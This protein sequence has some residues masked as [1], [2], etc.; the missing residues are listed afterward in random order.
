MSLR[1]ILQ[2]KVLF[3]VFLVVLLSA[4]NLLGQDNQKSAPPRFS[5]PPEQTQSDPLARD[6]L[7]AFIK[8][9]WEAAIREY[10]KLTKLSPQVPDYHLNL[11]ISYYS[12]GRPHE[13]VE[14]LRQALKLKPSLALARYYLGPSLAGS[15]QCK[16][17]LSYL[18]KDVSR[19]TEKH[20][21]YEMGLAGVRCSVALNQPNDTV[22][23]IRMLNREFPD[24][25]EVL[26]QTVH[27]YSDLSTRASQEIILRAPTSYQVHLLN[28]EVLESQGKWEDAAREYRAVLE[29]NPRLPGIHFRLGRLFLSV[30][31]SPTTVENARKEFEEE[32]KID[33]YNAGAEYVLGELDL[34][35]PDLDKA[36]GHLSRAVKLDAS[37]AD[38]YLELGRALISAE[39]VPEAVSPLE[40]AVKLQPE[41]PMAHFHLANAYSRLG[42]NEEAR[43][44]RA[45]HKELTEKMTQTRERV[46]KAVSGVTP[47]EPAK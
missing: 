17:A 24:D 36:I 28:A 12:F 37:F 9:D 22:D 41:N 43:R 4:E 31:K 33:P 14:P 16:E 10:N 47:P 45:L 26:Y 29:K 44:E 21:K 18:K 32:L 20:L 46:Q 39:R 30:P 35:V 40:T 6:A 38:A 11:G 19:A 25:P 42:R 34:Q 27:V 1:K 2:T 5:V 3:L 13:A 15:G 8:K 7:S 23:F